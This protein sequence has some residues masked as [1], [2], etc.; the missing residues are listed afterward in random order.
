LKSLHGDGLYNWPLSITSDKVGNV[1]IGGQVADSIFATNASGNIPAY[2]SVGGNTDF[3]IMKYGVDCNCTSM[4]V[5]NY[6]DTGTGPTRGFTYTGTTGV[7]SVVWD[8]GDGS[9]TVNSMSNQTHTYDT[10]SYE[11][12]V[13]AYT[14]CGSDMHCSRITVAHNE[15]IVTIQ[16]LGISVYPNP[17]TN[18][19]NITTQGAGISYRLMSITGVSLQSGLLQQGNNN[20]SLNGFASG[21]Y[22]IEMKDSNGQVSVVR[23]VKD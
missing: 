19:L 16:N 17:A 14:V 18:E 9:A 11:A 6:S 4:P 20:V 8:F 23:F 7:D 1:Y 2:Y 15:G 5:A 10:G 12:C 21:M 3:F 13:Y 22:I